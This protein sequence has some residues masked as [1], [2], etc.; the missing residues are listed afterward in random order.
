[1]TTQLARVERQIV[2]GRNDRACAMYLE[3]SALRRDV[4]KAQFLIDRLQPVT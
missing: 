1:M 2:T 3:A 4:Q